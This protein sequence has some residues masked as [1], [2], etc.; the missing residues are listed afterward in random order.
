[1]GFAPANDPQV[2][3]VAFD[4]PKVESEG[5]NYT[6]TG[7]YISGGQ[8]AAPIAGQLIADIL[9]YQGFEKGVHSQ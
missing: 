7:Y 5:S 2:S 6:T 9:D 3:L 1:M 4:S 8:L